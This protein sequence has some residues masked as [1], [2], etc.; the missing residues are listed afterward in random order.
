MIMYVM[1]TQNATI[2]ST[3]DVG[4]QNINV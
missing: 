3:P 2:L 1:R 4:A